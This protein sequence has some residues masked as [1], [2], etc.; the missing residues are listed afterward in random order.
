MGQITGPSVRFGA[1]AGPLS[2]LGCPCPVW[3][4]TLAASVQ[5]R[6]R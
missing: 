1:P 2:V 5:E 3:L 4:D 6:V